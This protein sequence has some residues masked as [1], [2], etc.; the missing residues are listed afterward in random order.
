M[1]RSAHQVGI[2]VSIPPGRGHLLA[3]PNES[4]PTLGLVQGNEAQVV[5][6]SNLLAEFSKAVVR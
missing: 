2:R 5:Q 3:Q 1:Q 6:Q 4:A